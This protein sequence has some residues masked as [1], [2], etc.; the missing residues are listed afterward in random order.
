MEKLE[1][2]VKAV[3]QAQTPGTPAQPQ[4]PQQPVTI[5]INNPGTPALDPGSDDS[6]IASENRADRSPPRDKSYSPPSVQSELQAQP[7]PELDSEYDANESAVSERPERSGLDSPS[8]PESPTKPFVSQTDQLR[9]RL[10]QA[11]QPLASSSYAPI[12]LARTDTSADRTGGASDIS[13]EYKGLGGKLAL[14]GQQGVEKAAQQRQAQHRADHTSPHGATRG[15]FDDLV[16]PVDEGFVFTPA[17]SK[18]GGKFDAPDTE[19]RVFGR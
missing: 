13:P 17:Q 1:K 19:E 14:F 15:Q 6:Q 16:R 4:R 11:Q 7:K 12:G 3:Q 5:N 9:E 8:T 2:E 18:A 10:A